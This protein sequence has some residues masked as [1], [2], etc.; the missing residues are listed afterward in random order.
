[1]ETGMRT[2]DRSDYLKK[3]YTLSLNYT[4]A[5]VWFNEGFVFMVRHGIFQLLFSFIVD[6]S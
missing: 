2:K 3:K 1:M 6:V 5:I 4:L